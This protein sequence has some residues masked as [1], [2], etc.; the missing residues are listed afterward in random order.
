[1][2]ESAAQ[3]ESTHEPH[4]VYLKDYQ[5][6]A[7]LID[8]IDLHFD[9]NEDATLVTANLRVRHNRFSAGKIKDLVLNGDG[10]TLESIKIN[11]NAVADN[12][13][14]VVD[15]L[16]TI[17]NVPDNFELEIKTKIYPQNNTA[18]S[19][20]Y[21]SANTYCTQCEAEGFRRITYFLDRP[22]VLSRYTTTITAD[23]KNYPVLLSNGNLI[24]S[25]KLPNGRHWVKWEDPFN[26]PSYLFALVAGDFDL[27]EDTFVT[28]S[29][30]EIMLRIYVEKGYGQQ[31]HHA[32]YSLK[33]AMRWDEKAYGREYDLDIYMIVAIGDFNM[34]AMENKGLNIFNTK[35]V[36]AKPETATDQDYIHILSVIG[37]E[38]FH[39]WSGNRVTCRDWFQL[40]LKEGLTIFRDQTFSEDTLSRAVMRI[41]EVNGLRE[42]QFTEDASPL[43]HPV[44]PDSYIEINNFY[45][46]TIYNKG[47]EVLRMLQTMLGKSMFRKGMDLYFARHDG[48]AVTIED[49]IK[50]ME[51]VSGIDLRQF[52]SWYSQAGTPVVSVE[53]DYDAE[54]GIYRLTIHQKTHP[55][56]GQ[57][58]KKPLDIP[59]RMG[60]LDQKGNEIPLHI[61]NEPVENEKVLRLNRESQIFAFENVTSQ[62]I[63]SLLRNFSAPVKLNYQYPDSA[64]EFLF[65]HDK[66]PFNRWEAGQNY[67]IRLLLNMIKDQQH[68]KPLHLP[69]EYIEMFDYVLRHDHDDNFLL[70]EMLTLPSEKYIGEQMEVVDVNAI[71]TAREF[72]IAEMA[73]ALQSLL[74]ETYHKNHD[75][76]ETYAFN[77][78]DIGRR[79][80]KNRCLLYL[81]LLPKYEEIGLNQF[82]ASLKT[83]MTDL[84][85]PLT[86]LANSESSHREKALE[87]FYTTWKHDA[88]VVDKWLAIQA[89]SKLPGTL[90]TVRKLMRHEA[91]DIKNPN[92]VYAL[93]GTFGQRNPVNFHAEDGEGYA[94]LREVV[95]Q[96]DKLN[97][98][99]AA[100]M[101]KPLTTWGRYD[102]E[103]QE[104]M[105]EQLELLLQD[106]KLS[107]DLY[108]IVSKSLGV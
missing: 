45:T 30:R 55:T 83:N 58:H 42:V 96:L 2:S 85:P 101:V 21:R 76:S 69:R 6:P 86:G 56:P 62:P 14:H 50:A 71:H 81:M 67:A 63:P 107:R 40:S 12:Q 97:P 46:A 65:K 68:D 11:G 5:V 36:L 48:Q 1:M 32:M 87:H 59:I 27:L 18:L 39:N 38:Y 25:G 92:K 99:V 52:R 91:F 77:I 23:E 43:A 15:Q 9:L 41:Q 22:D 88:L 13:F 70:A 98:Q 7:Y 16:L 8:E 28:Q 47:A 94:F 57:T 66:D 89:A 102:K 64:L 26:K 90:Q 72:V 29:N 106:K 53:D 78:H 95:H 35:Y 74:L 37:H 104:L 73:K 80:L 51:D 93:I 108:E 49:Y 60:L 24:D 105:Q 33:E 20:L 100:R 79:Q 54:R 61:Q 31:A 84:Q 82:E 19:G 3:T 34:G 4:P 17:H 103:R 10:L 44:R 75:S